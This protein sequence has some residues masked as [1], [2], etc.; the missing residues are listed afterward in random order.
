MKFTFI[1]AIC[2]LALTLGVMDARAAELDEKKA[3]IIWDKYCA[4]CHGEDAKA[5]T[6]IARKVNAADLTSEKIQ[7]KFGDNREELMEIISKGLSKR[8]KNIMKPLKEKLKKEEIENLALYV[9][10][11]SSKDQKKD[12]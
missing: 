5:R 4:F 6:T 2:A 7:R 9:L 1:T 8:D 11:L 10:K 12:K 3:K